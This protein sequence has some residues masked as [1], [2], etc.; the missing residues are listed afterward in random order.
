M[1]SG[2]RIAGLASGID[3]E[4]I[5]KDLM[6]AQRIPLQKLQQERQILEWKQ[7]DYREINTALRTF[8]DVAFNMKLQGTYMA[9]NTHSSNEDAVAAE[10]S[11]ST[12]QAA[13]PLR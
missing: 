8:R 9:K 3:T 12:R 2:L 5:I 10:C 1:A 13:T 7:E 4:S 6:N 11:S